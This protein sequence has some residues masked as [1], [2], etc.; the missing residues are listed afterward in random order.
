MQKESAVRAAASLPCRASANRP[1][2]CMAPRSPLL[3]T[4][5]CAPPPPSAPQVSLRNRLMVQADWVR[6]KI[7]GRALS[8]V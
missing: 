7:W 5:R 4:L 2:P 3:P 8:D 1:P 6:T